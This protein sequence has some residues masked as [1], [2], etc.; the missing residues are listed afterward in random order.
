MFFFSFRG[1][2]PNSVW[3]DALVFNLDRREIDF[4]QSISLDGGS[5]SDWLRSISRSSGL[6]ARMPVQ[7]ES[8]K[9]CQKHEENDGLV[10]GTMGGDRI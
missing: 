2:F 1:C 7:T 4:N 9:Q 5:V 8:G 10:V 6:I 3:L